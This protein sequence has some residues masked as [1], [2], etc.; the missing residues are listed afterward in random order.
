MSQQGL[1]VVR[2]VWE[3]HDGEDLVAAIREL[4]EHAGP[5]FERDA[6]LAWWAQDPGLQHLHPDI[7]WDMRAMGLALLHG[8]SELSRWWA[9]F[10]GAFET[11]VLHGV[12]YAEPTLGRLQTVRAGRGCSH[13]CL[14]VRLRATN[15]MR[16]LPRYQSVPK[17]V[18]HE[19]PGAVF[20]RERNIA[21]FARFTGV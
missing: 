11:Y 12:E 4:A 2:R 20:R 18:D 21:D 5:D 14:G 3:A 19:A 1:E 15:S 16:S 6:V 9:D 10:W 8:A 7:E 13:A 17:V